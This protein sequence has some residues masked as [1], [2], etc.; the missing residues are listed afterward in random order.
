MEQTT[1]EINF[2]KEESTALSIENKEV[3]QNFQQ[4]RIQLDRST[5]AYKEAQITLESYK[6]SN[7]ELTK[8]IEELKG[9]LAELH[10]SQAAGDG[11]PD[12]QRLKQERMAKM[13]AEIDPSGVLSKED[14]QLH[15]ALAS[16]SVDPATNGVTERSGLADPTALQT[17]LANKS[18]E[19]GELQKVIDGLRTENETLSQ[20][21]IDLESRFTGLELEYEELL[22]RTIAEEEANADFDIAETIQELKNRLEAQY[23]SK[24]DQLARELEAARTDRDLKAQENSTLQ[25]SIVELKQVIQELKANLADLRTRSVSTQDLPPDAANLAQRERDIEVLKKSMM[26]KLKEFDVM[27][28]AMMRD[29]QIRC[30]K[31]I[32]LEVALDETRDENN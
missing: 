12:K 13:M 18:T 17:Q 21:C 23:S 4:I 26:N 1:D 19:L 9:Q 31:I 7:C 8:S 28:K 25:A 15:E 16:L 22:D 5:H 11:V 2:L 27:R 6:L 14:G 10:Q 29:L 32:E 3:N 30:E 24:R 20:K